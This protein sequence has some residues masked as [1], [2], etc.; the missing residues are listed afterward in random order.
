[1]SL[2]IGRISATIRTTDPEV[3]APRY[4]V[5]DGLPRGLRRPERSSSEAFAD[6]RTYQAIRICAVHV[7]GTRT[8]ALYVQTDA[9]KAYRSRYGTWNDAVPDRAQARKDRNRC[10][11]VIFHHHH[12]H[13]QCG[14]RHVAAPDL[15]ARHPRIHQLLLG[16]RP[17]FYCLRNAEHSRLSNRHRR[18]DQQEKC[19]SCPSGV[20]SA[21]NSAIS[22]L[23]NAKRYHR[24]VCFCVSRRLQQSAS[25]AVVPEP[26]PERN[27]CDQEWNHNEQKDICV[28]PYKD[29]YTAEERRFAAVSAWRG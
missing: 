15:R 4:C 9:H 29:A 12:H 16:A 22:I 7:R 25:L 20:L 11:D 26:E 19:C 14:M 1:M 18:R 3:S 27:T 13:H 6:Y 5:L 21:M 8:Q 17:R 24:L 2:C 28:L 10:A 23:F